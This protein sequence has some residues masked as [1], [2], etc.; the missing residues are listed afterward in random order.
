MRKL[1]FIISICLLVTLTCCQ[2][3]QKKKP[4]ETKMNISG[5]PGPRTCF[6]SRGPVSA[7]PYMN[8][9]YPDAGVF[10]WSAVFTIPEGAT[11]KLE[12]EF[13]HSR[14]MSFIK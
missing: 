9:A 2:F 11:L 13:P 8:I 5:I 3:P 4:V 12:G 10:Y 1:I 6:W 14:Y 7:D